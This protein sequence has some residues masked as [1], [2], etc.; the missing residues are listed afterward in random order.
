MKEPYESYFRHNAWKVAERLIRKG[1]E[2]LFLRFLRAGYL[3]QTTRRKALKLCGELDR[4]S[5]S[6]YLLETGSKEQ[7]GKA[8]R[9]R[10]VL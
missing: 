4:V 7:G 3:T 8:K 9:S 2:A 10:F 5:L 6:A 1:E